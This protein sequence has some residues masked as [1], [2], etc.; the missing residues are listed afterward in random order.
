MPKSESH[1]R[2]LAADERGLAKTVLVAGAL[3]VAFAFC[4]TALVAKGTWAH[5]FFFKRSFV[6][7]VLLTAFGLGLVH[8][9]RRLPA[10]FKERRALREL[11]RGDQITTADTLVGRRWLQI[12]AAR[13]EHGLKNLGQSARSLAEHDEAEVDAAYR[14]SGDIV[15][16]LPL[17]GFF[18]TV[19]GLSHGLYQSF[20][21]TGGTTTKDFAKAIA[22]AF[23]NTLL[24][25][26]L[27]IILF[28]LQSILRKR[29]DGLLL[30][31]NLQ[32][33]DVVASAVQEP[34]KDPLQAAIEDLHVTVKAQE[35]AMKDLRV[36]LAK[37]RMT[38]E[39]PASGIQELILAH[40]TEVATAV[41]RQITADQR[42]EQE[43]TAR[44]LQSRMEEQA[45]KLLDLVAQRTL[46][47]AQL[48]QPLQ[49]DVAGI[50]AKIDD[51]SATAKL[52]TAEISRPEGT[53]ARPM[54]QELSAAVQ[55]LASAM[56]QQDTVLMERL[57]AFEAARTKQ[58]DSVAD[59]AR[60]TAQAVA[61]FGTRLDAV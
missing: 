16:I 18:G 9:V 26:A 13:G 43:R 45:G 57:Q 42:A 32:V 5:D 29:E 15:Q 44:L 7:W 6:Q 38:L 37:A 50:K 11:Q 14:L 34:T 53:S 54:L 2:L 27:T 20:L 56:S 10:W 19:F 17:I 51:L 59:E 25:L 58:L 4:L 61:G 46:A 36:E 49:A 28:T 30:Q 33:N 21:V 22:I 23:D 3:V 1:P 8:L 55:A 24:G 48:G 40:T 39:S 35:Q 52:I 47:F 60:N 12:E 41:M 31:L